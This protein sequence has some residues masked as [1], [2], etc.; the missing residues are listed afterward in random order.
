M[1]YVGNDLFTLSVR[2]RQQ[3]KTIEDILER[4]DMKK[5]F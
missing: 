3:R 2:A 4:P 1:R 5:I